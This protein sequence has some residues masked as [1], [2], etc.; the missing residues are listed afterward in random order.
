MGHPTN[1]IKTWLF[2]LIVAIWM[3]FAIPFTLLSFFLLEL[4]FWPSF[5]RD[6]TLEGITIWAV[7]AAFYYMTPVILIVIGRRWRAAA[8]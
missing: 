8:L 4:P 5:D 6:S 7:L 3:A 1:L 2:R